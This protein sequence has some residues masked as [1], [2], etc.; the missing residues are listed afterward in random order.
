LL[1]RGF[2]LMKHQFLSVF[3]EISPNFADSRKSDATESH[4]Q[5]NCF[6]SININLDSRSGRATASH[7]HLGIIIII[8]AVSFRHLQKFER[9]FSFFL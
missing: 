4:Q 7:S 9:Q 5:Q 1:A 3:C 6:K 8:I 2:F